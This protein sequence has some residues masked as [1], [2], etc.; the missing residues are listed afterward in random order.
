VIRKTKTPAP[1]Q[2]KIYEGWLW[3]KWDAAK[4]K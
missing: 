2:K 3:T 4:K 1:K